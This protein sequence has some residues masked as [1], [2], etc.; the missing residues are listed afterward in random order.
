MNNNLKTALITGA[1]S[2]IGLALARRFAKAK[3][4]LVIVSR[5]E[6]DLQTVKASLEHEFEIAVRTIQKDLSMPNSA[7]ELYDQIN[8]QGIIIDVL[9][10][11]AGYAEYGLFQDIPLLKEL[12][13]IE[14]NL[15]SA[16]TLLKLFVDE[17]IQRGSG[18]VLN[19]A[20]LAGFMPG[21]PLM[22]GYYATKA[23]LLSLTESLSTELKG[24]GVVI[25]VLAP[26]ATRTKFQDKA[27]INDTLLIKMGT[28]DANTVAE[29]GFA[30]LMAGKTIIIPGLMNK[31]QVQLLRI[32]PRTLT[33]SIIRKMQEKPS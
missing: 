2:G 3:Y 25:S 14:L 17:M 28:M 18:K 13:M 9:V 27:K 24:K 33:R 19:V 8:E 10:N 22:S 23:Y 31:L 21:G 4:N 30:G 20:S 7:Q 12:E 6:E 1:T 11:N 5:G 16:T 15:I 32:S 29:A 26:G